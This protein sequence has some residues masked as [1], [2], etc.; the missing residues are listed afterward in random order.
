MLQV[1]AK[2][3]IGVVIEL[4]LQW[5]SIAKFSSLIYEYNQAYQHD[6]ANLKLV[7]KVSQEPQA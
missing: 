5:R 2:S 7:F 4:R 3:K 6:Q 1:Q